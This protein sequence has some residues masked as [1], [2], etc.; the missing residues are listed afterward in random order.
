MK[1]KN[2]FVDN[3]DNIDNTKGIDNVNTAGIADTNATSQS[4]TATEGD[5]KGS[6]EK[7]GLFSQTLRR[8]FRYGSNMIVFAI[9]A[10]VL[11]IVLNVVLERFST[12]LTVDLTSEKLYTIGD[13]TK[14]SM[15]GLEKDVEII[16]L[17]DR[18][19]GEAD[20]QKMAIIKILDLYDQFDRINV[21][22]V[23]PDANPNFI[24]DTVG[25]VN[26]NSYSSGDYIVKCGEKTRRL[27]ESD[28]YVTTTQTYNS[29]YSYQV[30]TGMQ[31]E[32]KLTTAVLYVTADVSPVVYY[33]TGHSEESIEN[34][35]MVLTYIEGL[36]CD[37]VELDLGKVT[38]MPEDAS[39][40]IIMG[41][42]YDISPSEKVMLRQWLE[43]KGGQL[44]VAV[45]PLQN[46][47]E[48][49]NLNDL[50]V[51]M[52]AISLNQDQ[53]SDDDNRIAAAGNSF[54]FLGQSVSNG[55]IE[56]SSVYQ[57]PIFMSRSLTVMNIDETSAGINHYPII[58]TNAT[59]VSTAL[60]G[61]EKSK[62]GIFTVGAASKNLNFAE[63]TRAV[64]FCSSLAFSDTYYALYGAYTVRSLSIYAM[65]IDWM[66]SSYGDNAGSEITAKNYGSTNLVVTTAQST[67]LG[68]LATVIIPLIIIGIGIFVWIRRRHL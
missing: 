34:Y 26:A 12:A 23:D 67:R 6:N 43:Q 28:M 5:N 63:I 53:V 65:S 17:Y 8:R 30:Q 40:A 33:I 29:F 10:I 52:F 14:E 50:L 20:S 41:P 59:A 11:F 31:A 48:F 4:S 57:V 15:N 42:K 35:S 55:P 37:V 61:G 60:T 46:G 27:A 58:Q 38:E 2:D 21:S 36:G 24:L 44:A 39:V 22:Y 18:V 51:E 13:V 16:A 66:I 3:I 54:S 19:K 68:I 62:A 45:D 32:K 47:T 64:V 25:K 1:K 49:A 7:K 9:L 56:N